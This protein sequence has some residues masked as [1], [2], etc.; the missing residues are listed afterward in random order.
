L[1]GRDARAGRKGHKGRTT[2]LAVVEN[3]TVIRL[4]NEW[5][6]VGLVTELKRMRH[7][8]DRLIVG[9]DFAFSFPANYVRDKGWISVRDTWRAAK[10]CGE[11]WLA[12]GQAY[13][14]FWGR[15]PKPP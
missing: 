13:P 5:S 8:T 1:I 2:W 3:G 11:T 4:E 9:L 10:E 7:G 6:P 12:G 14:E 15:V